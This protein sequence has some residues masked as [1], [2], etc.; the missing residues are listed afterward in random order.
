M[1]AIL[2][3]RSTSRRAGNC[4]CDFCAEN[5]LANSSFGLNLILRS[6]TENVMMCQWQTPAA[7][8]SQDALFASNERCIAKAPNGLPVLMRPGAARLQVRWLQQR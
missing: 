3:Y 4:S 1:A 8:Q 2:L 7:L 6:G 5:K